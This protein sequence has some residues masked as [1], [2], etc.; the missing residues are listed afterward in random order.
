MHTAE[1]MFQILS[2]ALLSAAV[3]APL[4]HACPWQ[5]MCLS[6][7]HKY[8]TQPSCVY[9]PAFESLHLVESAAQNLKVA[10]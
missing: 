9:E 8:N 2:W 10:E 3:T 7:M 5:V 1:K 6:A 4:Q